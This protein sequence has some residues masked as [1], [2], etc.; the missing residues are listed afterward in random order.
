[1]GITDAHNHVWIE[2]VQGADPAAPVLDQF[3]LIRKELLA[4]QAAGGG[5]IL[6]CQPAAAGGMAI[7]WQSS[8]GCQG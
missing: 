1:M 8:R 5:S 3:D 7:T 2:P 4:Y 6:D